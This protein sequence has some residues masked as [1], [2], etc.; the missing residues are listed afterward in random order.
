MLRLVLVL[1]FVL[2]ALDAFA[3]TDP[4]EHPIG[5]PTV[6]PPTREGAS[7]MSDRIRGQVQVGERAPDFE[8]LA[9]GGTKFRLR[10][11][12]GH[13]VALFFT[14]RR[15][16]LNDLV[17]LSRTLDSLK[18]TSLVVCNEHVQTLTAWNAPHDS[19]LTP[20]AGDRGDIAAVYGLWDA[21]HTAIRPGLFLIDP[22][23]I[24]KVALLGQR[25]G[26]PSLP[27]LVQTAVGGL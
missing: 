26:A 20:L 23:G 12:R 6:V 8:L 9:T 17:G 1:A 14:D 19:R 2:A 27:G 5:T 22:E 15:A 16:D 18:F 25:V 4:R 11:V 3:Q 10:S 24:V 21:E 13:W 7:A